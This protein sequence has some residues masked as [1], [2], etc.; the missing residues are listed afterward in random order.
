MER[1][2]TS[3]ARGV[4][5]AEH[6]AGRPDSDSCIDISSIRLGT[7]RTCPPIN[8]RSIELARTLDPAAASSLFH[9]CF[10]VVRVGEEVALLF[11]CSEAITS[12]TVSLDKTHLSFTN[13]I[14]KQLS[15]RIIRVDYSI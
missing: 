14:I 12:R 3:S 6:V 9:G 11:V 7:T 4:R 15:F 2:V 10:T 8:L 5:S 1:L 13:F